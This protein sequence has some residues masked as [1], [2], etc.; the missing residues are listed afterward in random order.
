MK[1]ANTSQRWSSSRTSE[2][3]RCQPCTQLPLRE[4]FVKLREHLALQVGGVRLAA[5]ASERYFSF[6]VSSRRLSFSESMGF[7]I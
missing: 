5:K 7:T 6:S 3:S 4:S 1:E 2:V